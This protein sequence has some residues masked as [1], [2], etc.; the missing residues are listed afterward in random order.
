[1]FFSFFTRSVASKTMVAVMLSSLLSPMAAIAA[2][3]TLTVEAGIDQ[4]LTLGDA[5][6]LDGEAYAQGLDAASSG[7]VAATISW[8][9]GSSDSASTRMD[10][11]AVYLEGSHTYSSTGD[12]TVEVCADDLGDGVTACDSFVVTVEA[13]LLPDLTVNS[14]TVDPV[15][16]SLDVAVSNVG[17]GDVGEDADPTMD[18]TITT[19][20]DEGLPSP[21]SFDLESYITEDAD[22]RI[23]GSTMVVS[24][25]WAD[26]T[27]TLPEYCE[28][29]TDEES[30][31]DFSAL[32][33]SLDDVLESDETNNTYETTF[34]ICAGVEETVDFVASGLTFTDMGAGA[35]KVSVTFSNEG[36]ASVDASVGGNLVSYLNGVSGWSY[37]WTT[38]A[39]SITDFLTAGGTTTFDQ[40]GSYLNLVDGDV[41]ELCID[42]ANLVDEVD[43]TNNCISETFVDPS[44]GLPDLVID[45]VT[46]NADNTLHFVVSNQGTAEVD[47]TVLVPFHFFDQTNGDTTP[48]DTFYLND[49][50]IDYLSV[51]GTVEFDSMY[52]VPSLPVTILAVVDPANDVEELTEG[53]F[54][55]NYYRATFEAPITGDDDDDDTSDTLLPDLIVESITYVPVNV[56]TE[57]RP[58]MAPNLDIVVTNNGLADVASGDDFEF[59]YVRTLDDGTPFEWYVSLEGEDFPVGASVTLHSVDMFTI[60]DDTCLV[61]FIGGVDSEE[62]R[63]VE[64]NEENNLLEATFSLCEEETVD[65]TSS[66]GTPVRGGSSSSSNGGSSSSSN[67]GSEEVV[68]TEEEVAACGAM[69]FVDVTEETDGYESIYQLWCEGVIHGRDAMHFAPTDEVMRDEAVKIVT[70]LF[71]YITEAHDSLPEVTVTSYTD[72]ST[73]EPLAYY[74]ETMTD[75]GFFAEE[76]VIGEFRPH[77]DMTYSEIV[78]FLSEVSGEEVSVEGYE[79]TDSMSRGAFV[80]LVLGFFQ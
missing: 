10:A 30:T 26:E 72:V 64:S 61:D 6:V 58:V 73:D 42:T 31:W 35:Y 23:A 59:N 49:Y 11:S 71:G 40:F 7:I 67:G 8:G 54:E 56:G 66:G 20:A 33:D 77:E 47:A 50:G 78:D 37:N 21:M 28:T 22:F 68:L 14:I 48:D 45:S 29:V 16:Y 62:N 15:D 9:D 18:L 80:D 13:L 75:E 3:A 63:V 55:A 70:R 57:T 79:A 51:G 4:T 53:T 52:A 2:S 41:V 60:P 19:P 1:M 69:A 25:P 34:N 43:E 5:L 36:T 65:E 44:T 76:E 38:L 27:M 32:V 12:F 74:V 17:T 39:P 24:L 46:L